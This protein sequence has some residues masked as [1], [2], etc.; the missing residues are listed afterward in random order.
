[1]ETSYKN[2][3]FHTISSLTTLNNSDAFA[4]ATS[5]RS[6]SLNLPREIYLFKVNNTSTRKIFEMCS[7]LKIKI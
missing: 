4:T 6:S 1:M 5:G 3:I 2:L 7:K